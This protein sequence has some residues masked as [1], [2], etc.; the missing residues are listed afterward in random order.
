MGPFLAIARG[1]SNLKI[2]EITACVPEPYALLVGNVHIIVHDSVYNASCIKCN[3]T[4]CVTSVEDDTKIVVLYQ[5]AFIMI[6]VNIT[7][8]WNNEKKGDYRYGKRL[9]QH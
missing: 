2:T 9:T 1:S 3:L 8:P 5:P 6:P 7:G 4:N